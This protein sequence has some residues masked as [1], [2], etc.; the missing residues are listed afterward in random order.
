[1]EN[2]LLVVRGE[3]WGI[4]GEVSVVIKGQY[5]GI[6]EGNE[7]ILYFVVMNTQIYTCNKIS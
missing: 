7:I 3:G 5:K 1:M 4:L 2:R 6:L